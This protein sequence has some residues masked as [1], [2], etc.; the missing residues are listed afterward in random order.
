[1]NLFQFQFTDDELSVTR[2][3]FKELT[4]QKVSDMNSRTDPDPE[5]DREDAR[6]VAI[7]KGILARL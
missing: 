1:M 3:A 6:I 5:A 4:K 2:T 7:A